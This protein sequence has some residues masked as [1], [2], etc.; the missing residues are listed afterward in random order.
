[1]KKDYTGKRTT[2]ALDPELAKRIK[3]MLKVKKIILAEY[4]REALDDKLHI[5]ESKIVLMN[6]AKITST[7]QYHK[8]KQLEHDIEKLKKDHVTAKELNSLEL[9]TMRI[10]T[11]VDM[12]HKKLLG[13]VNSKIETYKEAIALLK[14]AQNNPI[15]RKELEKL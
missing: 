5:D 4:T 7:A 6:L 1:M 15:I 14:T 11:H 8:L 13:A 2:V 12:I 3:K 10:E 9:E